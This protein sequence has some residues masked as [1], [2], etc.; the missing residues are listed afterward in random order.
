MATPTLRCHLAPP[1]M[2]LFSTLRSRRSTALVVLMAW[3]FAL[4]SGVA[5]ACASELA[6]ADVDVP[7][8]R[9]SATLHAHDESAHHRSAGDHEDESD[10]SKAS[11][12]KFCDDGS[13]SIPTE[14]DGVDLSPPGMAPLSA[15]LW[16]ADASV[17]VTLRRRPGPHTG[18]P[19][20]PL[21]V[22]YSRLAL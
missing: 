20:L 14:F 10:A 4:A 18:V 22:R 2:K 7:S 15:V 6:E 3:L 8:A 5:N 9:V 16:A 17:D 21:R 12:L 1:D 11:C 19:L 13:H